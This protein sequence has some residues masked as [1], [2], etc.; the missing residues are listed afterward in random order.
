MIYSRS[1]EI[2]YYNSARSNKKLRIL[3]RY[4][5][6]ITKRLINSAEGV[7]LY[8]DRIVILT[9]TIGLFL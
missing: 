9:L 4:C 6:V 5:S 8:V 3:L 1:A 7:E 2:S